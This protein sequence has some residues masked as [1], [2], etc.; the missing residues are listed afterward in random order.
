MTSGP[1]FDSTLPIQSNVLMRE[2]DSTLQEA[3]AAF[4]ITPP[5]LSFTLLALNYILPVKESSMTVDKET[6]KMKLACYSFL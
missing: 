2:R 5:Y 6:P 1:G 3:G 4:R